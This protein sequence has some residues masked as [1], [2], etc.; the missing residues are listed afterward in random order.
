MTEAGGSTETGGFLGRLL[1]PF[2]EFRE[3]ERARRDR[4]Q[5]EI[6]RRL[7]AYVREVEEDYANA[8]HLEPKAYKELTAGEVRQASTPAY[9]HVQSTGSIRLHM[10]LPPDQ[11]ERSQLVQAL[12][13]PMDEETPDLFDVK[14]HEGRS[15]E[16]GYV[17]LGPAEQFLHTR[18]E[19]WRLYVELT[20]SLAV[21]GGRATINRRFYVLD[22][23]L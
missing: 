21:H 12:A 8:E 13:R 14:P 10:L 22:I 20:Y 16:H 5:A 17:I 9:E 7:E 23:V 1:A 4:E 18:G 2:R 6:G 15:K 19:N 3:R 11:M